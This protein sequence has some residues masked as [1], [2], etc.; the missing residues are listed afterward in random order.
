[1]MGMFFWVKKVVPALIVAADGSGDYATIQAAIDA[2]PAGGGQV[3]VKAGTYTITSAI[4]IDKSNVSII[5]AGKATKIQ[6]TSDVAMFYATGKTNIFFN[7][8]YLYGAGSGKTSNYG[9]FLISG[10][11]DITII[12]CFIE[13]C[14]NF[15]IEISGN[16]ALISYN[17]ITSNHSTAIVLT[18]NSDR[19]VIRDN[20]LSGNTSQGVSLDR[21]DYTIVIGNQCNDS[22]ANSGMD[23]LQC[24]NCLIKDNNCNNNY[25]YGIELK[26]ASNNTVMGNSCINNNQGSLNHNGIHLRDVNSSGS[27]SNIVTGNICFGNDYGIEIEDSNCSNNIIT[28]NVLSG[29]DTGAIDDNG[30]STQI[31]H[32]ITS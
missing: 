18:F 20:F 4:T 7:N 28:N 16:D 2:L 31:G 10:A 27:S 15:A 13:N 9:I 3:I 24:T 19:G 30:T 23:F 29:N 12:N 17:R 5:G 25:S 1:M 21:C 11:N 8:I 22:S 14:G 26:F 32:N 6:T